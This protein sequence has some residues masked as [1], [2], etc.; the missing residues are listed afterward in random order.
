[1]LFQ[2]GH[3]LCC[4]FQHSPQNTAH[5][6]KKENTMSANNA[7]YIRKKLSIPILIFH[8]VLDDSPISFPKGGNTGV[9]HCVIHTHFEVV[10]NNLNLKIY[11]FCQYVLLNR[12]RQASTKRFHPEGKIIQSNLV[13]PKDVFSTNFKLKLALLA[14]SKTFVYL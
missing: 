9:D 5:A 12:Q 3:C 1:M 10:E 14:E 6:F 8:F 13:F 7:V 11:F 4:R 2:P